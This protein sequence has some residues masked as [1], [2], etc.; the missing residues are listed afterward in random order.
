LA[1]EKATYHV[2]GEYLAE[3]NAGKDETQRRMLDLR[4]L[5]PHFDPDIQLTVLHVL[6]MDDDDY[7]RFK[8]HKPPRQGLN[9][10]SLVLKLTYGE[11]KL[12]FRGR[13]RGQGRHSWKGHFRGRT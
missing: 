7:E 9:N 12:S 1:K 3:V 11:V 8:W 4:Q 10:A 13:C 2:L 6:S 5:E